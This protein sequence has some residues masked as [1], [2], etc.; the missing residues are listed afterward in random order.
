MALIKCPACKKDVSSNAPSCL[1]CGEPIKSS[2]EKASGAV[3][4]KDPVHFIGLIAVVLMIL[5]F[6]FIATALSN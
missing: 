1:G 3:N 5:F 4:P 2:V 6:I